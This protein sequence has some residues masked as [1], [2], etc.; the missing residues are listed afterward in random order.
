MKCSKCGEKLKNQGAFCPN[1]GAE[2]LPNKQNAHKSL[3]KKAK[4]VIACVCVVALLISGTVGE[5][6]FFRNHTDNLTGLDSNYIS[7]AE[8]FTDML[9]TD[10]K[11]ALEAIKSVAGV[12]GIENVDDELK[13]SSTNAVGSDIYYRFGQYYNGIPVYGR[14]IVV[15][16]DG[17]GTV[18]ALTG[19]FVK[20]EDIQKYDL[21]KIDKENAVVYG[22]NPS[23][24][25]TISDENIEGEDYLVFTDV[26]SGDVVDRLCMTYT[27]SEK[28]YPHRETDGTYSLYDSKRNIRILNSN[29]KELEKTGFLPIEDGK[30]QRIFHTG[31][32]K[33]KRQNVFSDHWGKDEI[34]YIVNDNISV[35]KSNAVD[36]FDSSAT[37]LM[38]NV[39]LTYDFYFEKLKR[40]GFD[41]QNG[42]I[43]ASY[44]DNY[45]SGNNAYASGGSLLCFGKH[46]TLS[47]DLIAHEYTHSVEKAISN[48][49]YEGR[50]GAIMEG[51]SDIFGEIVEDYAD[52]KMNNNCDWIHGNRNIKEPLKTKNPEVYEGKNWKTTEDKLDKKGKSKNDHGHVHN[53]STVI[54]HTAYL[55]NIGIDGTESKKIDTE[56]L[57]KIWYKAL[58][59]LQSDAT[60]SQLRNAVELSARIMKENGELTEEQYSAVSQ[61]FEAA[62]ISN[63]V[64]TYFK[65]VKNDF[66]LLVLN[67]EGKK[68]LEAK[69]KI[70]KHSKSDFS[71]LPE[72]DTEKM[73][74]VEETVFNSLSPDIGEHF[75][76]DDGIYIVEISDNLSDSNKPLKMKL[77]VDGAYEYAT[78]KITVYTDFKEITT[79]VLNNEKIDLNTIYINFLC[80]KGYN[81]LI[82]DWY[83]VIPTDYAI[84]DINQDGR[85]ELIVSGSQGFLSFYSFAIFGYDAE[86]NSVFC[87]TYDID[88]GITGNIKDNDGLLQYYGSLR[89]SSKYKALMYSATNDGINNHYFSFDSLKDKKIHTEF[90]LAME[91]EYDTQIRSYYTNDTKID[92]ATYNAFIDELKP[93]EWTKI[94]NFESSNEG[95][96]P[97]KDGSKD[98][99]KFYGNDTP[100]Q[101]R[102]SI[103]GSWGAL[104]S[105][106]SEYNFIDSKNCS[107]S[108]PWQANGTYSISDDKT[109][110]ISW[111]GKSE[112]EKYIWSSETWDEFYSHSEHDVYFWY[113]TDDGV[114]MIN[115]KEK[116]RE[117]VDNFTYNTDGDLM[118]AISGTWIGNNGFKEYRINSDGTWEEST[119]VVSGGTLINRTTIDNGK[120][121]IIDNTTAKLWQETK[122]LSQIPGASE[123]VYDSKNDKIFVGGTNNS[124][125]RAKYK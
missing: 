24:I 60:F 87:Y 15:A 113:M 29:G 107:G 108:M 45:D 97:S 68:D 100:E 79:V 104:G 43:F 27:S 40:S 98:V 73:E 121:E 13:I 78:D 80:S 125:T 84:I 85:E 111:A 119:V 38:D 23:N 124:F 117:G 72:Y 2:M 49:N 76:L 120:V 92:E 67:P 39:A 53:N 30:Y 22:L 28:S 35:V 1:C 41:D 31:K 99:G 56:T 116:Y 65:T 48:M 4:A 82:T 20:I 6:Y 112:S 10:E 7:F 58:F 77:K 101:L 83:E 3:S 122:S 14:D 11:S 63:N 21:D 81:D 44:N 8:G 66:N 46:S 96:S 93:I 115:G 70:Y 71:F 88:D 102:K 5:L 59:V 103:I 86:T 89:Y 69:I 123:L 95:A 37:Q 34:E 109:L 91:T 61:A 26:K 74:L 118:A 75:K 110:I 9:V 90:M 32:N 106:V 16:A 62:G 19:N 42:L 52:G 57:A 47:V 36:G 55:M 54:S 33:D 17:N 25:C 94:P 50:S 114:L 105:I 12:I 51:Y 18:L 64:F